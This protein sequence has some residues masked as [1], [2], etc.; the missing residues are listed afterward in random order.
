M[1]VI[2]DG[3]DNVFPYPD[4]LAGNAKA[5]GAFL[6]PNEY[7]HTVQSATGFAAGRVSLDFVAFNFKPGVGGDANKL[8]TMARQ[9]G[10]KV[11]QAGDQDLA[12]QLRNSIARDTYSTR[13]LATKRTIGTAIRLSDE[14]HVDPSQ[15]WPI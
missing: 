11:Y 5:K 9:T 13:N 12:D 3:D 15:P 1:V 6:V 4:G 2:T 14:L 7:I 10:G 8:E